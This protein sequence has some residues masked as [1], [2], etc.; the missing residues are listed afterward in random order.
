M[1]TVCAR[2]CG[3]DVHKRTEVACL[4]RSTGT[5]VKT[6]GTMTADLLAMN[7]WRR[8]HGC[9]MVAMECTGS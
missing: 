5:E 6:F 7:V 8:E 9:Q 4:V 1:R 3:M 2:S